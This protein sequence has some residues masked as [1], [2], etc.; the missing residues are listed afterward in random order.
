[1][2]GT[3]HPQLTIND[4]ERGR[5]DADSFD[6]EAH[7]YMAWLYLDAYPVTDAIERFTTAL[8]RLTLKLGVPGKYHDTITWFFMLIIAERRTDEAS[9][10]WPTFKKDNDDLFRREDNVLNRYYSTETLATDEARRSFVLPD[11]LAA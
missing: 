5:V 4:F 11:R 7:I 1:M 3:T 8:K 9:R 10:V 6:H 2:A